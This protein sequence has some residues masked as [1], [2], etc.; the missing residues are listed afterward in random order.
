MESVKSI[1]PWQLCRA[2]SYFLK[3]NTVASPNDRAF[4][5]A[6]ETIYALIG[7]ADDLRSII[8]ELHEAKAQDQLLEVER[9][10]RPLAR[11]IIWCACEY[12][13]V[14][15]TTQKRKGVSR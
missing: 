3:N 4:W 15:P 11:S 8:S 6:C 5:K 12:R 9:V 10:I 14:V 13:E 7:A 2:A 1:T